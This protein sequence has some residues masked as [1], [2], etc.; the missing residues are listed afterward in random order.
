MFRLIQRRLTNKVLFNK[1]INKKNIRYLSTKNVN[2]NYDIGKS[3]LHTTVGIGLCVPFGY[4]YYDINNYCFGYEYCN[5]CKKKTEKRYIHCDKCDNCHSSLL[6]KECDI[7]GECVYNYGTHCETYG[8]NLHINNNE[9]EYHCNAC[10]EHHDLEWDNTR[11]ICPN[12]NKCF[13][14]NKYKKHSKNC[15]KK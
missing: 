3:I 12:C 8:C 4:Y 9:W 13:D 5:N 15:I 1:N 2:K 11:P 7:C 6:N 10:N 14:D